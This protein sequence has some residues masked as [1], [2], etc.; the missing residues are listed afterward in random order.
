MFEGLKDIV[1]DS[2]FE[3]LDKHYWKSG[4]NHTEES[5]ALMSATK[6][7]KPTWNKGLTGVQEQTE[8]KREKCRIAGAKAKHNPTRSAESNKKRSE[9]LKKYHAQKR[10]SK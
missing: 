5:K 7:G 10:V 3:P 1:I 8:E 9:A 4:W 6:K 2:D